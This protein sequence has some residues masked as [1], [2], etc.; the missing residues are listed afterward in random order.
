MVD[1]IRDSIQSSD[2]QRTCWLGIEPGITTEAEFVT[3]LES[4][5]Y[6]YET[7]FWREP[8]DHS[9]LIVWSESISVPYDYLNLRF[10][11]SVTTKNDIVDAL[12]F[13]P[14]NLSMNDALDLFPEPPDLVG[15]LGSPYRLY[16]NQGVMIDVASGAGLDVN[17]VFSIGLIDQERVHIE[18]AH[19]EDIR[20]C[21]ELI[22]I[23]NTPLQA[24]TLNP[25]SDTT[26]ANPT[27]SW[28]AENGVEAYLVSISSTT[29]IVKESFVATHVCGASDCPTTLSQPLAPD[30]Y[31]VAVQGVNNMAT[32]EWSNVETLR[33]LPSISCD[34]TTTLTDHFGLTWNYK[35]LQLCY[36]SV[37]IELE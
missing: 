8:E 25:I 30:T 23:C 28:S 36:G 27:I 14:E 16:A 19:S 24:P 33:I 31:A 10:A 5:G 22:A 12:W 15:V 17:N 29:T 37:V 9:Y 2:C 7:D 13:H 3:I 34:H 4:N 26:N 6:P 20:P 1:T 21:T 18:L 32:S 35:T 11:T